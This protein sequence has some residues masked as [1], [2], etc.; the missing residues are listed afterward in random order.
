MNTPFHGRQGTRLR[1]ATGLAG[2]LIV[3][4]CASTPPAPTASLQAA[5]QAIATAE[6]AE[7]GQHA[8]GD[9]AAARTKLASAGTAVSE[10]KM[11][12]A[13]RL[14]DEARAEAELASARTASVKANAM[15]DEMKSSTATLIQEM[16]RNAG[17]QQ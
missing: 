15:N 17:A 8:A 5:E 14:A 4:A 9:L 2:L 6:R 11:V 16:Q 12:I 13:E 10:K 7:A 1:I 3:T